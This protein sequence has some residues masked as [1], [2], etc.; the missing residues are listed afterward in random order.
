M[1]CERLGT[2]TP[3]NEHALH[4]AAPVLYTYRL[5]FPEEGTRCAKDLEFEA[6]DAWQ[7]LIIARQEARNNPAELWRDGEKLCTIRRQ[8]N[9]YWEINAAD[10]VFPG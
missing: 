6:S 8:G 1:T 9:E 10:R 3:A 7:A 4:H 2:G 5:K